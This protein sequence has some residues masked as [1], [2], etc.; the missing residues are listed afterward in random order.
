MSNESSPLT[1]ASMPAPASDASEAD[2]HIELAR[3]RAASADAWR[4][5]V[6]TGLVLHRQRAQYLEERNRDLEA[7][8]PPPSENE[9]RAAQQAPHLA[10]E[11]QRL[12]AEV[13]RLRTRRENSLP[14]RIKRRVRGTAAGR[15][16]YAILRKL[17]KPLP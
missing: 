4:G 7:P 9:R 10:A 5:Y 12:E 14:E 11:N 2:P 3:Q 1:R 13:M 15:V 17:R 6:E 16:L 8:L